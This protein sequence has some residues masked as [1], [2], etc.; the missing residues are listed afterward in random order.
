MSVSN[1]VEG[2]LCQKYIED[3]KKAAAQGYFSSAE[4]LFT[5]AVEAAEKL[6][7]DNRW[8][9]LSLERLVSFYVKQKKYEQAESFLS[10]LV[11]IQEMH[12]DGDH[13]NVL[14]R[15][16]QLA[17][18]YVSQSKYSKAEPLYCRILKSKEERF[19]LEHPQ[20]LKCLVDLASIYRIQRRFEEANDLFSRILSIVEK[21]AGPN[22]PCLAG[23]L[24]AY[25]DVL[26]KTNRGKE[27]SVMTYLA[28]RN[29]TKNRNSESTSAILQVR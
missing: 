4:K 9:L 28:G 14:D 16:E 13:P 15:Q 19:G 18:V 24:E 6:G 2:V 23:I 21:T 12:L 25:A 1:Q 29:R 8:L 7:S 20:L 11:Y 10:R 17:S 5:A 3:G 22:H 26:R 27:A